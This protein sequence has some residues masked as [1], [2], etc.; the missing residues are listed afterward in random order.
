MRPCIIA[1]LLVLATGTARADGEPKTFS[2]D[3]GLTV[4]LRPMAEVDT[5]C[6]LTLFEVGGIHDP[7]GQS[8]LAHL[9]EHLY[10]TSAAGDTPARTAEEAMQTYAH[11]S[12][13][14]AQVGQD[15]TV[16]AT[17]APKERLAA[18][19]IES[20]ARMGALEIT[21]GDV[22]REKQRI[23]VEIAGM[24]GE[25]AT[26]VPGLAA[27][28]LAREAAAPS[29]AGARRGGGPAQVETLTHAQAVAFWKRYP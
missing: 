11:P 2:L 15:Y 9:C 1:V 7:E 29:P 20:A 5:V 6:V 25:R 12:G 18:E 4:S 3:N 19:L 26:S 10:F 21:E 23:L 8:G 14:Q 28:N 16:I 24:F 27:L 13:W 22:A 17:V